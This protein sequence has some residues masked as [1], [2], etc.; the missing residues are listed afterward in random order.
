MA[1]DLD[2]HHANLTYYI[3]HI[4]GGYLA[5]N[6]NPTMKI[7]QFSQLDIDNEEIC[8]LHDTDSKR[9]EISFTVSDGLFNT[10]EQV[11][12]IEA[13]PVTLIQV[14]N[15]NLHVFPMSRKQIL[16]E[17]LFFKCSDGTR[18]VKYNISLPPH[19]G[20]ILYEYTESGQTQEVNTFSQDDINNGRILY[21]HTTPMS[22]LKTN[23]SFI[24][25]VVADMANK[26]H[27]QKFSVEISVSS[28]GLLRFL[29][30]SKL[31]VDEGGSIAI[32]LDFSKIL[33]YLKTRAGM[34]APELY[35]ESFQPNHGKVA[36]INGD[37]KA[38]KFVPE[39]FLAQRV[40]YIHDHS[41]TLDDK[42]LMSV[43]LQQ[44]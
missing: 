22:E 9:N 3:H 32:K 12:Y 18:G 44:G 28:G 14:V 23:D 38:T 6:S 43:Y 21:E 16:P 27:D 41:D 39:D 10:T 1:Q 31:N 19:L 4:Y 29:P 33:E 40:H 35:I 5:Y 13:N 20:R 37:Q 2:T 25:D 17:Q 30:V 42:V 15:E 34:L 7:D 36:L 8:F 26:L 11:L 24:F